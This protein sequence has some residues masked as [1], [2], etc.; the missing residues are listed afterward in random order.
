MLRSSPRHMAASTPERSLSG[1]GPLAQLTGCVLVTGGLG[2]TGLLAG[3]WIAETSLAARVVLLGRSGR[4]AALPP[5]A[6][7]SLRSLTVIR[8]DVACAEDLAAVVLELQ[9]HG[10]GPVQAAFHAGG[11]TQVGPLP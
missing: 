5:A 6:A 11:L 10:F 1:N 3:L 9:S 4:A 7:R 2:D 8:C